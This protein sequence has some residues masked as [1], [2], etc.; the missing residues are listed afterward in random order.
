MKPGR[1]A[2]VIFTIFI[3]LMVSIPILVVFGHIFYG[4]SEVWEHLYST[5]LK[6]YIINS[7]ILMLGVG[8]STI[9]I[10]VSTA[11][12][13]TM[14]Q[15]P[16]RKI[17][18]WSLILP[19]AMPAYIVGITYSGML[20]YTGPIQSLLRE[21]FGWNAGDYRFFDIMSIEGVIFVM[22]FVFYPYVYLI[23]RASFMQQSASVLEVSQSLGQTPLQTFFKV[24][25]PL[26]R[27]AIV[28]G[29]GLAL[30]EVLSDFGTVQYYG[31]DTF[32]TGI[33]RAWFSLGDENAATKLS[34]MLMLFVLALIVFERIQRGR[35]KFDFSSSQYRP[36]KVYTLRKIEA[37][38]AFSVCF[39]PLFFGFLLPVTQLMY[40][41]FLTVKEVINREFVSLL[42]NSFLLAVVAS[43]LSVVIAL[44]I[45]Y[46]V[47]L[48]RTYSVKAV[49]RIAT[50]GYSIPGVVVAVGVMIP[51]AWL[52]NTLDAFMSKNF[53]ISTGLLLSGTLF[54][55]IFAYIVRFLTVPFNSIEAGLERVSRNVDEASRSLGVTPVKTLFLINLPL[56]KGTLL[57]AA[58]LVFVDILKELPLTLILRP[59]NFDTLAIKA[60]ELAHDE[61]VPESA[62]AALVIIAVG[63]IPVIMLSK[64]ISTEK[65]P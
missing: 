37:F 47:R 26:A 43:I 54:A 2:W 24:A 35:A 21:Y 5:V 57:G 11:W 45:A 49:S 6:D 62:N 40:W 33:F 23:T 58:I 9:V 18:E 17:F 44:L 52:D 51:F 53:A 61:M 38:A 19:L 4:S 30:M 48:Y 50:S 15:F 20:D 65:R 31:V 46:A 28:G 13:V 7:L 25:L 56:I 12:V 3:A 59:F 39:I 1:N 29:V 14:Y 34:T 10:G 63:I 41:S 42:T 32:T 8:I 55:V 60:F 16:G 27:P 36:V 22:S 64:L